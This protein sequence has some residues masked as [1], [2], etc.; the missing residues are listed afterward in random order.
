MG[1]GSGTGDTAGGQRCPRCHPSTVAEALTEADC[2][3]V[4]PAVFCSRRPLAT[5]AGLFLYRR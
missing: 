4:Y 5:A 1:H 3:R 2:H